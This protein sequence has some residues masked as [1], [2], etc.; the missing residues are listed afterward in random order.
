MPR[1]LAIHHLGR[2]DLLGASWRYVPEA[3][4]LLAPKPQGEL[5]RFD[6]PSRDLTGDEF[7]V[8]VQL[9]GFGILLAQAPG[10]YSQSHHWARE[11][12]P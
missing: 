4:G 11:R 8:C 5:H 6:A 12:W 7:L 9:D 2:R 3:I 1:I 10:L